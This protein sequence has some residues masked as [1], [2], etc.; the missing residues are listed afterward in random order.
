MD[1]NTKLAFFLIALVIILY[2]YFMPK[3]QKVPVTEKPITTYESN[4]DDNKTEYAETTTVAELKPAEDILVDTTLYRMPDIKDV[5]IETDLYKAL[6]SNKGG[7]IKS[8][9]IKKY[10]SRDDSTKLI[11]LIFEN[12]ENLKTEIF[13]NN[14]QTLSG[15]IAETNKDNILLNSSRTNEELIMQYKDASGQL[16]FTKKYKFYNDKYSFD[17]SIDTTPIYDD[18]KD[19]SSI[20]VKWLD[21]LQYTEVSDN[22]KNLNREDYYRETYVKV[23]DE[24]YLDFDDNDDSE[25]ITGDIQWGATRTKYFELFIFDKEG[26]FNSFQNFPSNVPKTE[27]YT[28]M[29][30]SLT[31]DKNPDPVNNF[32]VYLGPMDNTILKSYDLDFDSTLNWGWSIIKPFSLAIYYTL[33]FL[34]RYIDNYG[35]V[36]ILLSLIVNTL[37]LPFTLKSYRSQAQMKKIQPYIK[38]LKEKYKGDMQKQQQATMELYKKHGVNPFGSCLPTLIPMPILYGMFIVFGATIEF[39]GANFAFWITDLS[40]PEVMFTLPFSIPMYGANVGLLPILMG[41][42][43]FY[44]MKDTMSADPNQKMM[45]YF[46]PVFLLVLF[47]NFASGLILYYTIGNVFRM[48]QQKF[49]TSSDK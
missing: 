4:L 21:G 14:G 16:L 15:L 13:L 9:K 26:Y 41:V 7:K 24:E 30:F 35:I 43:M 47:N 8:W 12:T 39:R 22:G 18:L 10:R 45:K 36:I 27:L 20:A 6:I 31:L 34:H 46:M 37:V 25:L 28:G 40:L 32:S 38:E 3:E 49:T 42:T 5:M 29:G 2:P 19:K 44:Q 1:K 48:V 33:T 11:D 23:K 17:V